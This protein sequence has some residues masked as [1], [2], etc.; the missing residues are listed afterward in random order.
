MTK[1]SIIK[2]RD[3]S[4]A[5]STA[6][7][8]TKVEGPDGHLWVDGNGK[9]TARCGTLAKP[10]PNAFSLVQI[11]DCPYRT[12]P[13]SSAC[14]VHGLE[15]HAPDT[16]ALYVHNSKRVREIVSR[17][18]TGVPEQWAHVLANW[19]DD[20]CPDFRWHVS[21]DV[22][23]FAYA[24]WIEL[25]CTWS[26]N[27]RHWIYTRS[28][29]YVEPLARA[30]NLVVN[31]SA[32]HENYRFARKVADDYDLRVCYLTRDGRVPSDMRDGD[33]VFPDYSLRG[34]VDW[35][36]ALTGREQEMVCPV[37]FHGKS[38]ERRCGPCERCMI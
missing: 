5:A 19:I 2:S 20:N 8:A 15:K 27:T 3:G 32:D 34:D 36:L 38:E 30:S 6:F 1:F 18:G 13:C 31:L 11:S 14:Y 37:D 12:A 25:V 28:F 4:T 24:E 17:V 16:H 22:F 9:I 33:V 23:S 10:R 29:P 26:P 7:C 35:F 21:G